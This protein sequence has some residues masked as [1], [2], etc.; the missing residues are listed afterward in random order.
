MGGKDHEGCEEGMVNYEGGQGVATIWV[1]FWL[2]VIA[3]VVF[4]M[5]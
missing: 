5:G 1:A 2:V 3:I 4:V